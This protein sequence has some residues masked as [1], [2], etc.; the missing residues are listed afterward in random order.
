MLSSCSFLGIKRNILGTVHLFVSLWGDWTSSPNLHSNQLDS[1]VD[2]AAKKQTVW[3]TAKCAQLSN[4]LRHHKNFFFAER[5]R[6]VTQQS[7]FRDSIWIFKSETIINLWL[8]LLVFAFVT[9]VISIILEKACPRKWNSDFE[10]ATREKSENLSTSTPEW[11]ET[12]K[13]TF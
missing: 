1:P 8:L 13:A 10:G 6:A 12:M 3:G 5:T 2:L 7:R 4:R 11:V 9:F